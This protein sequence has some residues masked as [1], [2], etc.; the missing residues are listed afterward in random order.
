MFTSSNLQG[1]VTAV[2]L[3]SIVICFHLISRFAMSRWEKFASSTLVWLIAHIMDGYVFFFQSVIIWFFDWVY[4]RVIIIVFNKPFRAMF[5]HP[6]S[7]RRNK[8]NTTMASAVKKWMML[9]RFQGVPGY[10]V[11]I[12][13]S[14]K[15]LTSSFCVC[16]YVYDNRC[17]NSSK[18]TQNVYG[19]ALHLQW[20]KGF[21]SWS[22]ALILRNSR[23]LFLSSRRNRS[24]LRINEYLSV[25]P[26]GA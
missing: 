4:F 20:L 12:K 11:K 6:C 10:A 14:K 7:F 13:G 17:H 15:V 19:V 21:F 24:Q 9:V 18:I 16:L 22:L 5:W 2:S 23:V 25:I 1:L 26:N 8:N 3:A